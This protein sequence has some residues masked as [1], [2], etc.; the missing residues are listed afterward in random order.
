[1]YLLCLKVKGEAFCVKSYSFLPS[2]LSPHALG[3][4]KTSMI[5]EGTHHPDL[6]QSVHPTLVA[7]VIGGGMVSPPNGSRYRTLA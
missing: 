4:G 7:T 3:R 5:Q 1:M 2:S 6:S